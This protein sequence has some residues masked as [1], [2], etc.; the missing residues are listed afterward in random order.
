MFGENDNE[1]DR[2]RH[3]GLT[4]YFATTRPVPVER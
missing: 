2:A 3:A 1:L 4:K